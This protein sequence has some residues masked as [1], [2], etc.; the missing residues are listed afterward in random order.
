M[1]RKYALFTLFIAL[2]IL[3]F[4][5]DEERIFKPNIGF[6][7]G[8]FSFYGDI[9]KGNKARS[10]LVSKLGYDM[11]LTQEVTPFLDGSFYFLFGKVGANER[12]LT[13]NVNFLSSVTI[14]GLS[15]S[16]N[17]NH[18][19]NEDRLIEPY[20]SLGIESVE[21]LSKTDLI[22]QFG[23]NY[24]Y[25]SDGTIRSIDENAI[26]SADAVRLERDFV[27]ESDVR[28]SNI[29]GFG[30]YSER[31]YA[32]PI[33][34]GANFKLT[35][36]LSFR[37]GTTLHY[38]FTDMIDGLSDESIGNRKGTKAN[39]SFV[40]T[41]FNLNYN[42]AFGLPKEGELDIMPEDLIAMDEDQDG[43]VDYRDECPGTPF[44]EIVDEKGCPLDDD[45]DGVPNYLDDEPDTPDSTLVNE[46]G[47]TITDKM[48]TDWYNRWID[49]LDQNVYMQ[50]IRDA[51]VHQSDIKLGGSKSGPKQYW[52]RI[53]DITGK[54]TKEQ[55]D[56][57]Q[58]L[59][60][61][62]TWTENGRVIIEAGPHSIMSDAEKTYVEIV[63]NGFSE[64]DIT[65]FKKDVLTGKKNTVQPGGSNL[66]PTILDDPAGEVIYRVQIG[67]FS[68]PAPNTFEELSDVIMV[69]FDD[70]IYRFF[71]GNST[72]Y[73]NAANKKVDLIL[74]GYD[75]AFIVAFKDNKRVSLGSTGSSTPVAESSEEVEEEVSPTINKDE[76]KFCVQIGAYQDQVPTS[77]LELFMSL[78]NV[79]DDLTPN[80]LTRYTAGSFNSYE[81]AKSYLESIK[82][83]GLKGIFIVGRYQGEVIKASE[84]I[85]MLKK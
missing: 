2:S 40:F 18:L 54:V 66:D 85:E 11:R 72:D 80:G 59:P 64:E 83:L 34:I 45:G 51:V 8:T 61:V 73:K 31:S 82:D 68:S 19:L 36:K 17:F 16:Y 74:D 71:V 58:N 70:G 41:S 29:D 60:G 52:V 22:D 35:N 32:I 23:N 75:G 55:A 25:W 14:G 81:E 69:P 65:I 53:D 10:P 28:N 44:E 76:I 6:G 48:I 42:I 12:S 20:F 78:D 5:Q 62:R 1:I 37:V 56:S 79:Q 63:K 77:I 3:G 30:K 67:A 38:T 33:G 9:T 49:T 15:A 21:F 47:V 43:V 57:L 46:K 24:H 4:A 50:D 27:Y 26:N 84:A 39:D 13:R 7:V